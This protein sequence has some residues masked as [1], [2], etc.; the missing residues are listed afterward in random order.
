MQPVSSGSLSVR[1]NAVNE[2]RAQ[3]VLCGS[4]VCGGFVID[5]AS[6]LT[7]AHVSPSDSDAAWF[8]E[9]LGGLLA[10]GLAGSGSMSDT[11]PLSDLVGGALA[12]MHAEF[13]RFEGADAVADED[14][15]S[16]S[17]AVFRF[18]DEQLELWSLGDCT[19]VVTLAGVVPV[20]IQDESVPRR[21]LAV[22]ESMV[23]RARDA[24]V[25]PRGVRAEFDDR[26]CAN[27]REKNTPAGYW[28]ADLTGVG[29]PHAAVEAWP[30]EQVV[31]ISVMSDGFAAAVEPLRLFGSL[32]ELG[33]AVASGDAAEILR[34]IREH[35]DADP[36]FVEHPRLKHSDD[37]SVV[38]VVR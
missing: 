12:T 8:S 35:E 25:P 16:A 29:V 33:E 6:G 32:G 38:W 34:S 31:S 7:A 2:D 1:G 18:A 4:S 19:T 30:V 3:V 21:D 22:V 37:A 15:P 10:A 11:E 23:R 36:D 9:R 5:G 17:L 14:R 20:V 26:L 28:I 13:E 27:R 24:D